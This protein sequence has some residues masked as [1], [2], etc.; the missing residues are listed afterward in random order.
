MCQVSL[1]FSKYSLVP[2]EESNMQVSA[3]ADSLCGISAI[4]QSVLIKERRKVLD[5]EKVSAARIQKIQK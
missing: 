4:D 1:E 3:D 5:A 2:G